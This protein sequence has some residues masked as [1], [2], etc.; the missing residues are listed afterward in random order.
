MPGACP[1]DISIPTA[2]SADG[3]S[4]GA[5]PHSGAT[6]SGQKTLV[7]TKV[8]VH[9]LFFIPGTW[10]VWQQILAISEII[11][12]FLKVFFKKN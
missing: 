4:A 11:S 1:C 7:W 2:P 3:C 6:I 8:E 5:P 12:H 9:T 10:G